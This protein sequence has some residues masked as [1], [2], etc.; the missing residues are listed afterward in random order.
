[1]II[2]KPISKLVERKIKTKEYSSLGDLSGGIKLL[3]LN[4][5]TY[6]KDGSMIYVDAKAIEVS[7]TG[8]VSRNLD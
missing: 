4:A 2:R 5:K 7:S 1:V 6:N 3:C 8:S